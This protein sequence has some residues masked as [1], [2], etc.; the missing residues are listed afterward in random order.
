MEESREYD[1]LFFLERNKLEGGEFNTV[2]EVYLNKQSSG[3]KVR[4][5]DHNRDQDTRQHDVMDKARIE[6]SWI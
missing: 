1:D 3:T 5:P 2:K 6:A 4:T